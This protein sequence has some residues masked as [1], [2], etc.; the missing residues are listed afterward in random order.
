MP[1][2]ECPRCAQTLAPPSVMEPDYR[3]RTHGV[4]PAL[5]PAIGFDA[6]DIQRLTAR[7]EVPVWI[8]SPLPQGWLLTGVRWTETP[9]R[10]CTGV[11]IG[12]SG[13]GLS[14]GPTDVLVVA[15]QPGCG[16]GARFAGLEQADPGM[17]LLGK[18]PVVQVRTGRTATGLWSLPTSADRVG[19]VGEAE[20]CWLWILG[21]PATA[22]GLVADELRLVDARSD[23]SYRELRAGAVNPRLDTGAATWAPED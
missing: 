20:G 23:T 21:W 13:H 18:R 22:W 19:F 5:V 6:A 17:W 9:R 14:V 12:V 8:P 2:V 16:L 15:E 1:A 10:A 3:C 7:S 11:A 4:V